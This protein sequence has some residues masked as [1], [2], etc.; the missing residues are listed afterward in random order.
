MIPFNLP[1]RKVLA[2]A[3]TAVDAAVATLLCNGVVNPHS[4]GIGGGF[5][6]TIHLA[7]GSAASLIA[8]DMAP[9]MANISMFTDSTNANAT[10]RG[11]LAIG[12]PGEI[13]GY[14]EAK[15]KFGNPEVIFVSAY[16]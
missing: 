16:N 11:P 2:Q 10:K 15:E 5:I 4:M 1:Y 9:Y 13:M 14:W 12:I 6:M 7:N 8:R 3:G